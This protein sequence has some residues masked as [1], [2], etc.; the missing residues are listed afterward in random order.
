MTE[1]LEILKVVWKAERLLEDGCHWKFHQFRYA[2]YY[3]IVVFLVEVHIQIS[4]LV[5]FSCYIAMI[6]LS[7]C[8]REI[9]QKCIC[10]FRSVI[11]SRSFVSARSPIPPFVAVCVAYFCVLLSSP[12]YYVLFCQNIYFASFISIF[13]PLFLS[14]VT[15]N[16]LLPLSHL[17][18]KFLAVRLLS[19]R[20]PCTQT[21]SQ[22]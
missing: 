3:H 21:A 4:L 15:S 22:Q 19:V 13:G 10:F 2:I 14:I 18:W 5:S 12:L 20:V 17:A 1:Q 8:I 16:I 9:A 11:V 7:L 6:S